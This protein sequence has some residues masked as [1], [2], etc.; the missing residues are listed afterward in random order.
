MAPLRL[1][2]LASLHLFSRVAGDRRRQTGV[3][4]LMYHG[5]RE[6]P[7]T[8][9]HPYYDINTSPAVFEQ[10]IRFLAENGYQ[11][12]TLDEIGA[13]DGVKRVVI[14]FDDGL[15][16]FYT[17]GY[18]ILQRYGF[19]ATVYLITGLTGEQPMQK[20]GNEFLCWPEV[21]ELAA[22]GIHFG[23]HTVSHPKL[24]L[25][26]HTAMDREVGT[27]K[28]AIED[29]LG[30]AVTSFSYP[31]AFPE[32]NRNLVQRLRESLMRHGYTTGVTT[33]IGR[34]DAQRDRFFVP[35]L[36]ANSF[37]DERFFQAKLEGAYDWLHAVQYST[38][39]LG[40]SK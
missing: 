27:S 30:L 35:R 22:N 20:M 37:D 3:P 2:R 15:R 6:E 25:M 23:S 38:K 11:A 1:D 4:V 31:Y 9:R 13:P 21:R 26:D 12:S 28:A 17:A 34:A 5:I 36:P 8:A 24:K 14:T 39:L 32:T 29:K 19:S 10:H 33:V 18:P 7:S 16:D 40:L